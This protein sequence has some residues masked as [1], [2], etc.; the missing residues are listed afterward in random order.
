MPNSRK[1]HRV[2]PDVKEQIIRRIKDDGIPVQQ[3]ATEHGVS[4][5]TV[6]TWLGKGVTGQP[7]VGELV[8]LKRENTM[9]LGLVGE[10]TVKLSA[11]QKKS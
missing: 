2:A 8:K 5:K 4:P 7:T 3:V 1:Y 6:W 10:L 11:A 9:L